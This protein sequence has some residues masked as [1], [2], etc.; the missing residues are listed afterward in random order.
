MVV[1]Q[2]YYGAMDVSVQDGFLQLIVTSHWQQDMHVCAHILEIFRNF[3]N[4]EIS[5]ILKDSKSFFSFTTSQNHAHKEKR[6]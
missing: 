6:N 4:A 1:T 2:T 3:K 5:D